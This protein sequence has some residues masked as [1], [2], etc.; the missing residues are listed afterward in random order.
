MKQ[1]TMKRLFAAVLS[2]AMLVTAAPVTP[3]Q[4]PKINPAPDQTVPAVK[5]SA[6]PTAA[7]TMNPTAEPALTPNTIPPEQQ[8]S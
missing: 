8:R 5:P 4:Q 2:A 1:R 3:S 6:E 7:P